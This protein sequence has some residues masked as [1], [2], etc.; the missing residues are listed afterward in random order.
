MESL[1][2]KIIN[3]A[4]N[5]SL[6]KEERDLMLEKI[7]KQVYYKAHVLNTKKD[8][9]SPY[10]YHF[11]M[12]LSLHEK[13][14][15]PVAVFVILIVFGGTSFAANFALPGQALYGMKVN[16]N[17]EMESWM[18]LSPN[19]NARFETVKAD[20]RL[21]EVEKLT[22]QKK[23]ITPKAKAQI[24]ENFAKNAQN[25][26]KIVAEIEASGGADLAAEVKEEFE[27]KLEAH[28]VVLSKLASEE[29]TI[30]EIDDAGKSDI[31][32]IGAM[33][34]EHISVLKTEQDAKVETEAKVKSDN[35][36][37]E[38]AKKAESETKA[39]EEIKD[40]TKS[41]A[42]A[43]MSA[44]LESKSGLEVK[45][46]TEVKKDLKTEAKKEESKKLEAQN[47]KDSE[48]KAEEKEKVKG[49]KVK[50]EVNNILTELELPLVVD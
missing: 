24:K 41:E 32:E 48:K 46:T 14:F 43:L 29:D 13:R 19:A 26:K 31:K 5:V 40:S 50:V 47:L 12:G 44:D 21:K 15:V 30:V 35:E 18:A 25:V 8:I 2:N 33:V 23:K 45:P 37:K 9:Q 6:T 20:R 7:H 34:D 16:V 11:R 36:S 10:L 39:E 1:W 17:E 3:E 4:K 49:E 22:V 42:S 38:E 28:S 27:N